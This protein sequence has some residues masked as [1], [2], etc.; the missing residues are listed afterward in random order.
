VSIPLPTWWRAGLAG[1]AGLA[2]LVG[3]SLGVRSCERYWSGHKQAKMSKATTAQVA[4]DSG[5]KVA[6]RYADS[7]FLESAARADSIAQLLQSSQ[8]S[9][10]REQQARTEAKQ[11]KARLA[12]ARTVRDSLDAALQVIASQ[13]TA[14]AAAAARA[15]SDSLQ[16]ILLTRDRDSWKHSSDT[17]LTAL[18]RYRKSSELWAKAAKASECSLD[19]FG[20]IR[21]PARSTIAVLAGAGGAILG[22]AIVAIVHR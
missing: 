15:R 12:A 11:A 5:A 14:L 1:L 18:D 3:I 7:I 19:P 13:D 8:G 6:R 2:V 10:A 17:A 20:L 22:G 9:A 21:C 4:A 16:I